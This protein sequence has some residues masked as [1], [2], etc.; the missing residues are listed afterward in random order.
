MPER[1]SPEHAA[2]HAAGPEPAA[3]LSERIRGALAGD[4][5]VNELDVQVTI[6]GG[7]IFLNGHV[8]TVERRDAITAIVREIAPGAL[9]ANEVTVTTLREPDE[10][11]VLG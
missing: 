2:G 1:P 5:R 4:R 9:V 8:A 11:E 7:R 6:A 3:Y 10:E